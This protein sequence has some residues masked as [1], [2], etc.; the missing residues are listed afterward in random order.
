MKGVCIL[1][2]IMSS[3]ELP[4]PANALATGL[5]V[6]RPSQPLSHVI[7]ITALARRQRRVWEARFSGEGSGAPRKQK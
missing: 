4:G 2:M 1:L 6:H 7:S 3:D 5:T